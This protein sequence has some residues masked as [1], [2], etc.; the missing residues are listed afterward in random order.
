MSEKQPQCI[1]CGEVLE[2]GEL[3]FSISDAKVHRTEIQGGA[4]GGV[5][6]HQCGVEWIKEQIRCAE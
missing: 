6:H 1:K 5:F 3:V 4:G 2:D